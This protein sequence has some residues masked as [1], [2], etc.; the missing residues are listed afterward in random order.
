ML[1]RN[2]ENSIYLRK[3]SKS[4]LV[5]YK[6]EQQTGHYMFNASGWD[7]PITQEDVEGIQKDVREICE[8]QDD[9]PVVILNIVRL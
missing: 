6:T 9:E 7:Q 3:A 5:S 8:L 2:R 1:N 4:I